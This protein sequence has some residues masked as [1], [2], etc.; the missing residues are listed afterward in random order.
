MKKFAVALTIIGAVMAGGTA[1]AQ[2]ASY[3]NGNSRVPTIN[4]SI[5]SPGGQ[6]TVVVGCI[7]P[8]SITFDFL[9]TTF[10]VICANN[11]LTQAESLDGTASATF[12]APTTPGT[13]SGTV[14]FPTTA[15]QTF[16]ITVQAVTGTTNPSGGLPPTGSDSTGSTIIIAT[17]LLLAGVAMFAVAQRRRRDATSDAPVAV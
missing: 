14:D 13:Y 8:E 17:T 1:N 16:T 4:P 9:G 12:T 3:N 10:T 2:D 7:I 11:R 5:V 15:D 6:F